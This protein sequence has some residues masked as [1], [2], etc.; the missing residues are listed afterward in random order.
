MDNY[1]KYLN[2]IETDEIEIVFDYPIEE[3]VS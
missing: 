1:Y 3:H 2:N